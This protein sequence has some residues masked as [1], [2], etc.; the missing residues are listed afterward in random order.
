MAYLDG[1]CC[2]GP[3]LRPSD[4]LC[5]FLDYGGVWY[6]SVLCS[7]GVVLGL[8]PPSS[9][10]FAVSLR[11]SHRGSGPPRAFTYSLGA[12]NATG[13]QGKHNVLAQLSPGLF[14]A[15]ETHLTSRGVHEFN[16]GLYHAQSPFRF[17]PGAPAHA[18]SHSSFAGD[19]TGVGFFTSV[20]TRAACQSW[21]PDVYATARLQVVN[22]FLSLFGSLLE[23]VMDLRRGLLPERFSCWITCRRGS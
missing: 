1:F 10:A 17:I 14:A 11:S 16:R 6:H 5:C 21:H 13:L 18:R 7:H 9:F 20:P 12:L 2:P 22:A 23:S 3:R 15:S 19:Y 8:H 4:G